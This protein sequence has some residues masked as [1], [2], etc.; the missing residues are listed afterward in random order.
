MASTVSLQ[1][2]L[3][4]EVQDNDSLLAG[5]LRAGIG[6][7][8]ECSSGGC[9]AC[10]FDLI[11][12]AVEDTYPDAPG[13]SARDRTRGKKLA[14]QSSLKEGCSIRVNT[15]EEYVPVV[16]PSRT[17]LMLEGIRDITGDLRE[18]TFRSATAAEFLPGQ[19]AMLVVPGEERP[20]AYS[21]SNL[22]NADGVWQFI[23]KRVPNGKVTALLFDDLQ[24]GSQVALDGPYGNAWFRSESAKP[25]I[26]IAGGS[27]LAPV[28][29]IAR[30]AAQDATNREIHLFY[31]GRSESDVFDD[32][33]VDLRTCGGHELRFRNAISNPAPDWKGATGFIHTLVDAEFEWRLVNYEFYFAGPPPMLS[34]IQEMLMVKYQVPFKQI[35]F[36]RFF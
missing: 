19:Y 25:I 1:N 16:P 24:P 30:A 10:R 2:G 32:A 21:M 26:C 14:C 5:A 20:R 4:F 13:L 22:P 17:T 3:T 28:L 35:H 12:G 15:G 27:G 23:I 9:G 18:F 6:F 7:P 8:Y 31:G 29:S 36:D 33:L 11:S 34:A